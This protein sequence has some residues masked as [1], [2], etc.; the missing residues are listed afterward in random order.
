MNE[1]PGRDFRSLADLHVRRGG[2]LVMR[3]RAGMLFCYVLFPFIMEVH[4]FQLDATNWPPACIYP[5]R[6]MPH[7]E[8][9]LVTVIVLVRVDF[10]GQLP[11]KC[12]ISSA[13]EACR[14]TVSGGYEQHQFAAGLAS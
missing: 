1:S 7:S 10:S 3:K 6:G 12:I 11:D 14:V 2:G 5:S 4:S 8:L 13:G 9:M